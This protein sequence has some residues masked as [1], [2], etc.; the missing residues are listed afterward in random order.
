[1]WLLNNLK[2]LNQ[3][4]AS[5]NVYPHTKNWNHSSIYWLIADPVLGITFRMPKW[6]WSHLYKWTE[7]NRCIYEWQTTYKKI[8]F[9][10]QLIL[11]IKLTHHFALLCACLGIPDHTHFKWLNIFVASIDAWPRTKIIVHTSASLWDIGI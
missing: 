4:V 11:K 8:K 7:L 3:H 1:M 9:I 10:S 5:E 6:A 2:W